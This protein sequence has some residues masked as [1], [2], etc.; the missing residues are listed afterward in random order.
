MVAF[1]QAIALPFCSFI[2]AEMGAEVVKIERPGTGDVVRGWD[3]AVEGLSSGFVAFNAGKRDIAV[4]VSV[5]EGATIVR[6]LAGR[7]DVFLENFA[8]G[9]SDRLGLGA[10]VLCTDNPRLVY[11]SLSG[12]GQD[13]PYRDIK[14]YDLLVQGESGVLLTNGY[15]DAP[16]KVGM[17][18]T[19]LMAGATVAA[20]V[21]ASLLERE[22]TGRGTYLDV[23]LLDTAFSWLGYFPH[24]VWH[25]HDPPPRTGM[26]HQFICPYGPFLAADGRYVNLA[27]ASQEHWTLLCREVID[28][29]GWLDDPRFATMEARRRNR[30][31]LDALVAEIIATRPR[32][33]WFELLERAGLPFGE[34]REIPEVVGH[35]QLAHRRMIVEATSPVGPI[36]LARFALSDPDRPRHVPGLGEH[37]REVLKD[38]GLPDSELDD[39]FSRGIIA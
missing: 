5:P 7:A 27:A 37:T 17:P 6:K 1:E 15:P 10:N 23:A 18:I 31:V 3:D 24:Y 28:R 39:L 36:P 38:M 19:D 34:V 14:A 8:P 35:P 25:G 16:A 26:R 11:C 30:E 4:D 20:G 32:D 13:G 12:Y 33:E 2:L 21:A 22:D 9:V 29:P